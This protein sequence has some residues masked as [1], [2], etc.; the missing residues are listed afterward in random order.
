MDWIKPRLS[1]LAF[2]NL[3][4]FSNGNKC[5]SLLHWNWQYEILSPKRNVKV[6]Y[7]PNDDQLEVLV[8]N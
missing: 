2:D 7:S 5:V 4:K 8:F 3:S 6:C 1:V